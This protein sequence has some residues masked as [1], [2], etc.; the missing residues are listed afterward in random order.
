MDVL[1]IF[2][3]EPRI[4]KERINFNEDLDF[5]QRYRMHPNAFN[6]LL[7]EI[8]DTLQHPTLRNQALSREQQLL[9]ALR[10]LGT[11]GYY[12]LLRD[13]HG[14]S[15]STVCVVIKRV[16]NAIN[17]RLFDQ[18]VK[19]PNN[20]I[21]ISRDFYDIAHMPSV[22]GLVDGTHINIKRPRENEYQFVN[23]H[24]KHSINTLLVCGPT[25]EYYYC[26]ASWPGS[27]NDARIMRTSNLWR[28]FED[29]FRPFPGAVIL[30]DS[31]FPCRDWLIPPAEREPQV[32]A[33]QLFN[34]AHKKTRS[35]IENSFSL[36]KSRFAC[37]Q[38]LR[39]KDPVY[40]AEIIKACVTL[41]NFCIQNNDGWLDD[42]LLER[43]DEIIQVDHNIMEQQQRRREL[44]ATFAQVQNAN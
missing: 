6:I 2:G 21:N 35:L 8:G 14:P 42:Q 34:N 4:F 19:F 16:V 28:S 39:V 17:Q 3:R 18:Y 30:G 7:E 33:V 29:G 38:N 41:H 37:L 40:S 11:N 20:A 1:N 25:L 9:L 44:I 12:H 10:F 22:C 23:R 31:I 32:G 5:Y 15:E 36:L 24:G 26:N 13:A 27:V 43:N